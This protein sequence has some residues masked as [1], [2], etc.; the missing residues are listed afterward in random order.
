VCDCWFKADKQYEVTLSIVR[1]KE[2]LMDGFK[3][4]NCPIMAKELSLDEM[5]LFLKPSSVHNRRGHPGKT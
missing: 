1:G 4:Q 3:I 2:Q 5:V